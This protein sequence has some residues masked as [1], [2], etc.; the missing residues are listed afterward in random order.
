VRDPIHLPEDELRTSEFATDCVVV[1]VA[2]S[3]AVPDL[4]GLVEA[5]SQQAALPQA[6]LA[7]QGPLLQQHQ[8]GASPR[9]G[10]NV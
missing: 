4:P 3:G 2:S 9:A 10:R 7:G 5:L 8:N 1:E 6:G